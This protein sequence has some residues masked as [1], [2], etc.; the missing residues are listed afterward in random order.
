MQLLRT[1]IYCS[2]SEIAMGMTE[3]AR[4]RQAKFS[5]PRILL[6]LSPTLD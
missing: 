4:Y 1:L 5:R 3:Q 6:K 2:V